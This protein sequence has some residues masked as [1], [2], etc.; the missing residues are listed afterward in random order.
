M[1]QVNDR[2]ETGIWWPSSQSQRAAKGRSAQIA[3]DCYRFTI[4]KRTKRYHNGW[5]TVQGRSAE[6]LEADSGGGSDT[7]EPLQQVTE[8][9]KVMVSLNGLWSFCSNYTGKEGIWMMVRG[10]NIDSNA[11]PLDHE[12]SQLSFTPPFLHS[13]RTM[14]THILWT[15]RTGQRHVYNALKYGCS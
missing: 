12:Q 8:Y 5:T 11:H 1:K 2:K 4:Q 6:G 7:E 3:T 10:Q 14:A 9:G 13:N 15:E